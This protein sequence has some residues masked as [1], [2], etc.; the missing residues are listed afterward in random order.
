MLQKTAASEW[1]AAVF[2]GHLRGGPDSTL[3]GKFKSSFGLE[4]FRE[5]YII[6]KK[7]LHILAGAALKNTARG[8]I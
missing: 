8:E 5:K 4:F 7:E 1:D 3:I 6:K 2:F